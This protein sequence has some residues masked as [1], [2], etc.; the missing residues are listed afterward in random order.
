MASTRDLKKR[1]VSVKNTQQTTKAMKMV[2]ASKLRRA[3]NAIVNNRPFSR[4]L[5][6]MIALVGRSLEGM[7]EKISADSPEGLCLYGRFKN[8]L[9]ESEKPRVLVVCI[10]SDRGLCGGF[11]SNVIKATARWVN[12][13]K[14]KYQSIEVGFVGRRGFDFFKTKNNIFRTQYLF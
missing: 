8:G 14:S 11:N 12:E 2:S 13:N 3:Q 6:S 7:E 1:I 9:S 10:S 4:E 5:N